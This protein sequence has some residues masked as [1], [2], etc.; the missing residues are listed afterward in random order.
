MAKEKDMKNEENH[1]RSNV[2]LFENENLALD[3]QDH[4]QLK[5]PWQGP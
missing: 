3:P 5:T 4:P 1:E 2:E